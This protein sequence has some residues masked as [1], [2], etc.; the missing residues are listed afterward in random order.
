MPPITHCIYYL[1]GWGVGYRQL[2]HIPLAHSAHQIPRT[3]ILQMWKIT[4]E[5]GADLVILYSS[6]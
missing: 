1:C 5:V 3:N 2:M 6:A 4:P